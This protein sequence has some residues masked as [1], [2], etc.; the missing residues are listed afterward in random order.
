MKPGFVLALTLAGAGFALSALAAEK[1]TD[2]P[3]ASSEIALMRLGYERDLIEASLAPLKA[4][5]TTLATLEKQFATERDYDA[6][7]TARDE[8]KRLQNELSRLDKELLLL[9]T[10]EQAL[11][12]S[13]LP[14]RIKFP[15]ENATLSGVRLEGGAITGWSQVGASASWKLPSLPPGGYEVLLRYRC[16]AAEG[17]RLLIKEARYTL[18]TSIET[19]IKGPEERS[20]GTLKVS[21]GA[22]TLTL[23]ADA[24]VSD[25]LMQ[26]LAVEL[27]P[28]S[29]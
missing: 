25:N 14:D 27:V 12:T 5:I 28:A 21:D 22:S 6:A 15:L 26:L 17:G 9:Q 29:R 8:R 20:A 19:T 3:G 2:D 4:Q 1:R 18:T 10:R 13:L 23:S 7:I 24:L 11:K 16:R